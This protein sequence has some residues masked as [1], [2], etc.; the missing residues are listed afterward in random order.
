MDSDRKLYQR[1]ETWVV[2]SGLVMAILV[3]LLLTTTT[4]MPEPVTTLEIVT[5]P[6]GATVTWN[7]LEK[8]AS[9]ITLQAKGKLDGQLTIFMNQYRPVKRQI[10]LETGKSQRIRYD[11]EFDTY[12]KVESDP[13]GAKIMIDGKFWGST[14]MTFDGLVSPGNHE[15]IIDDTDYCYGQTTK[16]IVIEEK[17]HLEIKETLPKLSLVTITSNPKGAKVEANGKDWGTTPLS[18]CVA[19]GKYKVK[20][21]KEGLVTEERDIEIKEDFSYT[22]RLYDKEHYALK[23]S[24]AVSADQKDASITAI[25][26]AA[27]DP[28][29]VVG[30]PV[31]FDKAFSINKT[32]MY[33]KTG[34]DGAPY[35]YIFIASKPGFAPAIMQALEPGEYHLMLKGISSLSAQLQSK[36]LEY[37]SKSSISESL[38]SPDSKFT[39]MANGDKATLSDGSTTKELYLADSSEPSGNSFAWSSDSTAVFY[40]RNNKDARELLRVDLSDM[41]E[42][43]I[44]SVK[45]KDFYWAK[46]FPAE[47]IFQCMTSVCYDSGKLYYLIPGNGQ[48]TM[49][50]VSKDATGGQRRIMGRDLLPLADKY[51]IGMD[52]FGILKIG[53][54][55]PGSKY[56]EGL[57]HIAKDMPINMKI[58]TPDKLNIGNYKV[59]DSEWVLYEAMHCVD[60]SEDNLMIAVRLYTK[61]DGLFLFETSSSYFEL[62]G[63]RVQ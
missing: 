8:G 11:L 51:T 63:V 40:F 13:I 42:T 27:G 48:K 16:K 52:R 31:A 19:L 26:L 21:T 54:V 36:N 46:T 17:K 39:I 35:A 62:H 18:K 57:Y 25:A 49:T 29:V 3:F 32:E 45:T 20:F 2:F 4:R 23:D 34:I 56:F 53:G 47:L 41:K 43:V 6:P 12:M 9:P 61:L 55:F 30:T 7:S 22:I 58:Q 50:L 38:S 1:P 37:N 24:Y 44:D 60:S 28:P 10:V 15:L 59:L 33:K 14:P 5:N